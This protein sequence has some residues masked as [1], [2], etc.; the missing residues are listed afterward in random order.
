MNWLKATNMEIQ[1]Q[2]DGAWSSQILPLRPIVVTWIAETRVTFAGASGD[3]S[4]G[5]SETTVWA[6]DTDHSVTYGPALNGNWQWYLNL[7]PG[8]SF[9]AAAGF[10]VA[11]LGTTQGGTLQVFLDLLDATGAALT[12]ASM[13]A[14]YSVDLTTPMAF[15]YS[16]TATQ[17]IVGTES[18]PA[19]NAVRVR[20]NCSNTNLSDLLG[21]GSLGASSNPSA[22]VIWPYGLPWIEKAALG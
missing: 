10:D 20:C 14:D 3:I 2:T 5:A 8:F 4:V 16:M 7:F 12:T 9:P 13:S 17:P 19:W 22:V 21:D 15:T 18:F 11:Y 1:T 6:D